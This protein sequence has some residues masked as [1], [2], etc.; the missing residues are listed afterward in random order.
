MPSSECLG[1]S[2][3]PTPTTGSLKQQGDNVPPPSD[4]SDAAFVSNSMPPMHISEQVQQPVDVQTH[5]SGTCRNKDSVPSGQ[6]GFC[7]QRYYF[8][9]HWS[10]EAVEKALEV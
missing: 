5:D 7:A 4:Q 3:A 1:E 10:M 9:P 6:L 8:S 2:T